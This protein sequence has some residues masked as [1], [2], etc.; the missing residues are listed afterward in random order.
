MGGESGRLLK[1]TS[2]RQAEHLVKLA[3]EERQGS[4][5][6]VNLGE[7]PDA[8]C[9]MSMKRR[10]SAWMYSWD[11]VKMAYRWQGG[12]RRHLH[13]RRLKC[14]LSNISSPL[15]ARGAQFSSPHHCI[16]VAYASP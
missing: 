8:A 3:T 6:P 16:D 10:R 11:D 12:F 5:K 13:F 2:T 7:E 9:I 15:E 14:F 1:T 4:G